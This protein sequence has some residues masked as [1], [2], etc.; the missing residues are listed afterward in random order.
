MILPEIEVEID[1]D[2]YLPCY[3]HLLNDDSID[4]DILWGGRD[5]GKS[6]FLG[7]K[8]VEDCMSRDYYR[9]ILVKETHEAIKDSQYALIEE[10][11]QEWD[12]QSLFKFTKSPLEII[13][14]NKNKFL[15]RGT[16]NPGKFRSITNPSD[17]WI[18]EGNQL[19]EDAFITI[20]TSIRNKRGRV[21]LNISLNPEATCPDFEDFWIYKLFFKGKSKKNFTDKIKIDIPND[22]PLYFTYRST[23]TTY[24]DNPFVTKQR[25]A[26]HESLQSLNFYWYKIFTLGE[27]GN[28][29]ND[30][31]WLF[32]F[33]RRKHIATAELFASRAETLYLSFDFN[34][35]PQVCTVIQWPGEREVKIIEVIKVP[36]V[37]TE[38]ICDIV[39]AKYPN[40]LYVVTGDYSGETPSSLYKEQVTNYTVIKNKL[41]LTD[42]QIKIKP[43]PRLEK[44]QTLVN[45]IFHNYPVQM[46]P[47]KAKPAIFD[48]ENVKKRADGTIIKENRNDAAQQADVLDTL[49]YWFNMFMG[50]YVKL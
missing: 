49:R 45:T 30:C 5:S 9:G 8:S 33:D 22:D 17:I 20:L 4:I 7:Q 50:W 21:K 34:R 16:D 39:L 18:E 14:L 48:C 3:H 1:K 26:F 23:H 10:V 2:V 44:N 37:G 40:Y 41:H 15:A 47:V 38:G 24:H 13:C 25:R 35:N 43:N 29:Q 19:T 12:L 27:W 11:V 28:Q 42:G 6:H 32:A 31:P 46:C 36:N